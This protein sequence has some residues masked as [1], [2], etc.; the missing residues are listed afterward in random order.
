MCVLVLE[1]TDLTKSP[2]IWSSV[3]LDPMQGGERAERVY[4]MAWGK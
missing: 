2:S 4:G 1:P 3:D